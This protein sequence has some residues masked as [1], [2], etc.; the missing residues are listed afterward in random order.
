MIDL[1]KVLGISFIYEQAR[2]KFE[3]VEITSEFCSACPIAH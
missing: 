3:R 2:G 1:L